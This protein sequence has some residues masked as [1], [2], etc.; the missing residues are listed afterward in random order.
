MII[1]DPRASI[2]GLC[3]GREKEFGY[4]PDYTFNMIMEH[5]FQSQDMWNKYQFNLGNKFKVV[6]NEEMHNNLEKSMHEIA[7]WLGVDYNNSL[8]YSTL[9]TGKPAPTDSKYLEHGKEPQSLDIYYL[10]E[11][12]K[13]RWMSVL[14]DPREILMIEDLLHDIFIAFKYE[15]MTKR[16]LTSHI[17]GLVYFLLPHRGLIKKW[18][19]LYPDIEEFDRIE[20]RLNRGNNL[21]A[22]KIWRLLPKVIKLIIIILHS[23]FRR[24]KIYYFP[25]ERWQRY[26]FPIQQL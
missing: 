11:N 16:T 21:I 24:I 9:A 10:P 14:K 7:A 12:V 20:D 19:K 5:W 18:M 6:K 22:Q 13:E 15:R 2:A 8:L 26:D 17:K 25:G 4:L 3:Y 23:I 1:R